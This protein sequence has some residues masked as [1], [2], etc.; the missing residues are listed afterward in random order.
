MIWAGKLRLLVATGAL[1]LLFGGSA[2]ADSI[3]VSLSCYANPPVFGV[4]VSCLNSSGNSNLVTGNTDGSS[5]GFDYF[6]NAINVTLYNSAAGRPEGYAG[7]DS[8]NFGG[9]PGGLP[10]TTNPT[11]GADVVAVPILLTM[12]G[13]VEFPDPGASIT[14]DLTGTLDGTTL[15][16]IAT[17]I[18]ADCPPGS[19]FCPFTISLPGV[20]APANVATETL[21]ISSTG[22]V[23]YQND[24]TF[25]GA[26]EPTTLALL[27]SGL[28]FM[29]IMIRRLK[30]A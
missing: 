1:L 27:T 4:V 23:L 28:L 30:A 7:A 24:D 20:A 13:A 16:I 6:Y 15:N 21:A 29:L 5:A 19:G 22:R 3:P 12:N 17:F 25:V 8:A 9:G 2:R 26:P 10:V 14:L 18:S 11:W